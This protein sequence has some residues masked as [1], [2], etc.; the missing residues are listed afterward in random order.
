M[1]ALVCDL[2]RRE[3]PSKLTSLKSRRDQAV[4]LH[5]RGHINH[6]IAFYK[7]YLKHNP[8][9]TCIWSNL[10]VCLRA[11]KKYQA[12]LAC[13][14]RALQLEPDNCAALGNLGNVLKDLHRLD[15]AIAVHQRLLET[16]P[17]DVQALMNHSSALR[18]HRQF[19][20]ALAQLD[21]ALTLEP[22]NAAISWERGQNLLH[23]GQLPGGIRGL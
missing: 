17:E 7:A 19:D 22:D 11:Q 12:A 2:D 20:A 4:V 8:E 9:D 23:L 21:K 16:R 18:E 10:G 14:H 3:L 15:D 5:R 6:A 1:D 13:H